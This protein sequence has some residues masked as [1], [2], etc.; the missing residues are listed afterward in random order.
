MTQPVFQSFWHGN[1]L[2]PYETMC[3]K[4]FIDHGHTYHLYSYGP[5]D[6]PDGC[7]VMNAAEILPREQVF[8]YQKGGSFS[9]FS[10]WFRYKLLHMRGGWWVDTDMVCICDVWPEEPRQVGYEDDK[11]INGAV[12]RAE[13]GD[14]MMAEAFGIAEAHG[15]DVSWGQIGPKLVTQLAVTGSYDYKIWDVAKFYPLH[16]E[17]FQLFFRPEFVTIDEL[18][19]L[20]SVGVHLWNEMLRIYKISKAVAPP[21]HSLLWQFFEKAG[22]L[23]LFETQYIYNAEQ[24]GFEGPLPR[25]QVTPQLVEAMLK[26]VRDNPL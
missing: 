3:I 7:V 13:P 9:A 21:P 17:Q 16:W 8:A 1:P 11:I 2:T 6:V 12:I 22:L 24:K 19:A 14:P 25:A 26:M 15:Q 10:N 5:L 23:H 20:G 4:S 18:R